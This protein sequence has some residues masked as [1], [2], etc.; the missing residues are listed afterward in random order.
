[1]RATKLPST[2]K[3]SWIRFA[4]S[5]IRSQGVFGLSQGT[6]ESLVLAVERF[7]FA[8]LV[9]TAD[10]LTMSRGSERAVARDNVIFE[11]GLFMGSLGRDRTFV[12]HDRSRAPALP[13]DLAGITT[14]TFEPHSS[15]NLEAALGAACTKIERAVERLGVRRGAASAATDGSYGHS[16]DRR[17]ARPE[18]V[19]LLARSRKV[20]LDIISA[21][22]GAFIEPSKLAQ[23]RKDLEDL[24]S[25]LKGK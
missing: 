7:D 11:L 20:E 24:E 3:F 25:K 18:L 8:T 23:V 2:F 16:R 22:F 9:L 15:G 4:K 12:V 5:R 13:T 14:A 1:M 21:Q 17:R 19:Q 6:L 10:D